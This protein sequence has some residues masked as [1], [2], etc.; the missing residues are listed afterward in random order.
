MPRGRG[1]LFETTHH[2][3][4]SLSLALPNL[5]GME[6]NNPKVTFELENAALFHIMQHGFF[7]EY[8]VSSRPR[9]TNLCGA[10]Q[11]MARFWQTSALP[12]VKWLPTNRTCDRTQS[13][14][15]ALSSSHRRL[16]KF[17]NGILTAPD[18]KGRTT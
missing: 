13:I 1:S 9:I 6:G 16:K 18:Q 7:Q 17:V 15:Q 5:I 14:P 10:P 2:H 11:W 8:A 4:S 12:A 3:D